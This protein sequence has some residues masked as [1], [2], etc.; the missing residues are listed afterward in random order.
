[1]VALPHACRECRGSGMRVYGH[2]EQR[3]AALKAALASKMVLVHPRAGTVIMP[4]TPAP[5]RL[6][7]V[8]YRS[9]HVLPQWDGQGK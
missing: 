5:S 6:R 8:R 4:P 3:G 1:M 2:W 9:R 7:I